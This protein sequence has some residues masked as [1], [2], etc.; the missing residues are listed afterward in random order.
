MIEELENFLKNQAKKITDYLFEQVE[1][2]V[3]QK[4]NLD[5]YEVVGMI[6]ERKVLEALDIKPTLLRKWR[7]ELGLK[8]YKPNKDSNKAYYDIEELKEFVKRVED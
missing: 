8:R 1:K 5:V 2:F 4:S 3:R 7:L 6:P